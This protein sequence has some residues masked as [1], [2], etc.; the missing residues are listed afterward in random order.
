[1]FRSIL[2]VLA[3][4]VVL[5]VASFAIE[6]AV[7]PLLLHTFPNALPNQDA[8]SS[9]HWVKA[10][11]FLYGF[12]CVAG[13]GYVAALL[14]RRSPVAHATATGIVQA[15][16]TVLAMLSP[17]V[18]HASRAQWIAI[19]IASVPAASIGGIFRRRS[20]RGGSPTHAPVVM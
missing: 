12:L 8:L 19:A 3:G 20:A 5:T 9:N 18:S 14:A 6:A 10:F 15:G 13:G 4:V 2:S 11:G 7:D 1:M 17:V 16:L